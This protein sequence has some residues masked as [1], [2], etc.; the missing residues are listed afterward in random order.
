[1]EVAYPLRPLPRPDEGPALTARVSIPEASLWEPESPFLYEGTVELWHETECQDRVAVRHGLR[2]VTL[3]P[4]GLWINGRP[5]ALRGR[6]LERLSEQEARELR[7]AGFNL[8]VAPVRDA[9]GSLWDLGDRFGLFVLGQVTVAD[10]SPP[11]LLRR[12][13]AHASCLGWL[14]TATAL[15]PGGWLAAALPRTGRVLVGVEGPIVGPLPP[16]VQFLA[17]PAGAGGFAGDGAVPMLMLQANGSGRGPEEGPV[18][19]RVD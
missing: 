14:G 3:G 16:G 11:R 19:G 5:L 8:V 12:L 2:L 7:R 1:V 17:C 13:E 4:R 9:T 18:L 10:H 6:T 15:A